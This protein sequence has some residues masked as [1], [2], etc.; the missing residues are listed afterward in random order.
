VL[1]VL[2]VGTILLLRAIDRTQQLIALAAFARILSVTMAP[3][4]HLVQ[5]LLGRV[6][7]AIVLHVAVLVVV[8]GSTA[9]I[10]GQIRIESEA[11]AMFTDEQI[12]EVDGWTRDFL[13][14]TQ[15]D[16]RLQESSAAWGTTAIVAVAVAVAVGLPAAV[17]IA[18]WAALLSMVPLIGTAI[19]WAPLVVVAAAI[20]S[21]Q[22]TVFVGTVCVIGI[23]ATNV[24]RARYLR[25]P[26]AP[27]S[28]VVAMGIAAGL[29]VA[30]LAGL[31]P[32]CSWWS[33]WSLRSSGRSTTTARHR[34]G[35]RSTHGR[36]HP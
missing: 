33:R 5:K 26:V 11:L 8:I 34:P 30:G 2:V 18:C 19:G 10:V 14:R 28:F 17:L 36:G 4:V 31:R 24:A 3:V 27:G 7:A 20:H 12:S 1:G 13:D 35:R 23:I 25:V 16:H 15:L 29:T 9:A 32:P 21:V 22:T 6:G